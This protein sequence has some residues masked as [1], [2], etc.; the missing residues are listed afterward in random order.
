MLVESR[1]VFDAD[2][3]SVWPKEA[4]SPALRWERASIASIPAF[5][6]KASSEGGEI[7]AK[8][9]LAESKS[10]GLLAVARPPAPHSL[11]QE[12]NQPDLHGKQVCSR[13]LTWILCSWARNTQTFGSCDLRKSGAAFKDRKPQTAPTMLGTTA[14]SFS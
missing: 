3:N 4:S 9:P 2:K 1:K 6:A 5:T 8:G 14:T 12:G 10:L 11:F 13:R 7:L